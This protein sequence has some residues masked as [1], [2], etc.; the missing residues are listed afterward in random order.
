MVFKPAP[1]IVLKRSVLEECVDEEVLTN[2][3]A[4]EDI[5]DD[6]AGKVLM[7]VVDLSVVNKGDVVV[8]ALVGIGKSVSVDFVDA[9]TDDVIG[10]SDVVA[11]VSDD[12]AAIDDVDDDDAGV[13]DVGDVADDEVAGFADDIAAPDDVTGVANSVSDGTVDDSVDD[14]VDS[15]VSV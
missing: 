8:E 10:V 3:D 4:I 15:F 6:F 14:F 9:F 11:G 2:K 12:I 13:S 5:G 7:V 1:C